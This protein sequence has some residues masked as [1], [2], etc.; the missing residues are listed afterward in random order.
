MRRRPSG[1]PPLLRAA[2]RVLLILGIVMLIPAGQTLMSTTVRP[3]ATTMMPRS[4]A[5]TGSPPSTVLIHAGATP[6]LLPTRTPTATPTPT[7]RPTRTP[8]STPTP[9]TTATPTA[10]PPYPLKVSAN[11]RYLVD[12]YGAP[13]MLV[14][15]SPQALIVNVSLTDAATFMADRKAA[16][17][18]ALWVNLLCNSYTGG[19]PDGSTYDG[20]LPFTTP[21]DLSTPNEAYFARVDAMI[22]LAAHDGLTVLLDPIE[23]GGWLGIIDSNG[24]AKD[25]KYGVYLGNRYKSFP[26]IVWMSGNDFQTW[27]NRTD[28]AN[29]RAVAHGIAAADPAHLQ[30]VELNYLT[31]G[32]LDDPTWRLPIRLDAA[33]TYYPTYAQVLKEYNRTHFLPTFMVEANYEFEDNNGL[34]YGSPQTLRRQEYWTMLSGAKGQFYG[35]HYTWQFLSGW[36]TQMDTPGSAQVGYLADLFAPRQWY[37]LVPDQSHSVVTAG[38]GTFASS[39]SIGSNDY[40][41]AAR[42][43]DGS[44]VMAYLPISTTITVD[45][46]KLSAPAIARWYDPTNGLYSTIAGSPLS[47]T[48]TW[49]FTP[50]GPN[51]TGDP[52]W[53]LVLEA[54]TSKRP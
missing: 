48:G 14:G 42:T 47:N 40:V 36:Q 12:Q 25:F 46:T 23:T 7:R 45:L 17:F 30:T 3:A 38:Y 37:D 22:S 6:R 18:N 29:V 52:D 33:Y 21:G 24:A 49:Q 9:T 54:A 15:D 39:G 43:P 50:P 53:V 44:L 34:D 31:S 27:G 16:G 1:W 11:R 13:F 5:A 35:N 8:T 32:S 2:A 19:R 28:D 26:N 20:I 4:P 10:T 41:T 51:S